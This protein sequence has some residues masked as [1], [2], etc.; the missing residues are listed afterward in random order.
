MVEFALPAN[1]RVGVGKTWAAPAGAIRV[2]KLLGLSLEPRR[3]AKRP[4]RHF[5]IDLN[6]CGPMV[7]DALSKIENEIEPALTF[8]RSCREHLRIRRN[9][10][11]RHRLARLHQ[12]INEIK[13]DVRIYPLPHMPVIKDLVPNLDSRP[14]A[15]PLDRVIV[16][17]TGC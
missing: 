1:S 14:R 10:H 13:G 17:L 6:A 15:I 9:K 12:E 7:L 16:P 8:R 5:W 11:R 2:K 3:R 4:A